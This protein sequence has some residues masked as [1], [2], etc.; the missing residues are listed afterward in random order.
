[1]SP[2]HAG[3]RG[4]PRAEREAQILDA[5]TALFGEYGYQGTS[6]GAIAE[7]ADVSK[8]LV[9]SYFV[10][11]DDLYRRCVERLGDLM[12]ARVL[13]VVERSEP[14]LAMALDTL[15]T[16]F[17]L[18]RDRP[19]D[20]LV[21][22]DPA[23]STGSPVAELAAEYRDRLVGFGATGIR[24]LLEG[25]GDRDV[26]PLDVSAMNH[27]WQSIVFAIMSWWFEHPEETPET[28]TERFL[29]ILDAMLPSQG[30]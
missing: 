2:H 19:R 18:V 20:W 17:E 24:S 26:D 7:R 15:V 30:S 28:L 27:V 14:G 11:K 3:T 9:L 10:C 29:R 12:L 4:V 21:I 6:L 5:A 13:P 23:R 25:A 22:Y 16:M 1:M 8:S